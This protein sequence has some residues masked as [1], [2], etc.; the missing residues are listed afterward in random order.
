[1]K[2]DTLVVIPMKEPHLAKTRLKDA[3]NSGERARFARHLF[4]RTLQIVLAA[5]DSHGG[6]FD[7]A[8]VTKDRSIRQ[9][10]RARGVRVIDEQ[11]GAGL[12]E[13]IAGAAT[14]AIAAGY[15]RMCVVPADL[16]SPDPQDIGLLLSQQ[17]G[18]RGVAVCPS[19][20]FGTNAL[21]VT[22]PDV[23]EFAYGAHSF[24]AHCRHAEQAGITPL[25]PTLQSL[26]WD[27]DSC[28][29]LAELALVAPDVLAVDG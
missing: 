8:V 1:M 23:I 20:D 25:I 12:N 18:A 14:A 6:R 27:V 10:S 17:Q 4:E 7:M 13:A 15:R 28:D 19:R 22:P 21:L 29:D 9:F 11:E 5:R 24:H 2:H 3:L 16:A 26:R